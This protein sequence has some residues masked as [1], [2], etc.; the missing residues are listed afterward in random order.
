MHVVEVVCTVVDTRKKR[1]A[2]TCKVSERPTFFI[3]LWN[4]LS[5]SE[6][7]RTSHTAK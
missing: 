4:S 7:M 6:W 3:V 5:I 1:L 2:I